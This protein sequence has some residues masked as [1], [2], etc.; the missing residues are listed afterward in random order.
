M[1]LDVDNLNNY[2]GSFT[3]KTDNYVVFFDSDEAGLVKTKKA[4][5]KTFFLNNLDTLIESKTTSQFS[6]TKGS[7][8]I[9]FRA[10]LGSIQAGEEGLVK[11]ATAFE[12]ISKNTVAS[13]DGCTGAIEITGTVNE[14]TVTTSCPTVTIGLPDNV[15]IPYLSVTGATFAGS[16]KI[17]GNLGL[18]NG[19]NITSAVTTFNGASGAVSYY[20][21]FASASVTGVASFDTASGLSAGATGHVR[22]VSVPNSSLANSSFTLRDE[23]GGTDTISLG[24]TLTI[25]GGLGVDFLRTGTD[26]YQVRGITA[27][28]SV[29]GVA[30]F[31]ATRFSVVAGA[32]DLAAPY[33]ITGDTVAAVGSASA[34]RSGSNVTIDNRLATT[35]LTGVASFSTN[36]FDVTNGAVT[37]KTGGVPNAALA[38]S[39]FILRDEVGLTDTISLGDT[40]TITGGRGVDFIRTATDT[41]EVRGITATSS[42]LG[43]AS[44]NSS[45]FTVSSGAVSLTNAARTN[46]ANTFTGLQT[47]TTGITSM[48]G[49]FHYGVTFGDFL[50]SQNVNYFRM[51]SDVFTLLNVLGSRINLGLTSSAGVYVNNDGESTVYIYGNVI[52][53]TGASFGGNVTAN[54]FIGTIAGGSF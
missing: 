49:Q 7:D 40:L 27:T 5:L 42:V 25:T 12:Y 39:S 48:G 15:Q 35:S 38:N 50:S 6:R 34:T 30:S 13:V 9:E 4:S 19:Q 54:K 41:Y 51:E 43:V 21:A 47:F 16:V 45:D 26:T 23:V 44:F 14:V 18:Q 20:P 2:T 46:T 1:Y 53:T 17:N 36:N 52:G 32:V 24:D 8:T 10:V 28:S 3:S 33:Q 37:I 31:N 29:L 11:G 22:L